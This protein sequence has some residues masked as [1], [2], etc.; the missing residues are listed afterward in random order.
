MNSRRLDAIRTNGNK[1]I[2]EAVNNID[3]AS[4]YRR[5]MDPASAMMD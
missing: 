5:G 1:I 2:G 3:A 4:N